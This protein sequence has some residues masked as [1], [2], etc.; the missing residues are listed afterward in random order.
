MRYYFLPEN[1][2]KQNARMILASGICALVV[3]MAFSLFWARFS[4]VALFSDLLGCALLFCGALR[5]EIDRMRVPVFL[6]ALAFCMRIAL[7]IWDPAG[8]FSFLLSLPFSVAVMAGELC[9]LEQLSLFWRA[10]ASEEYSKTLTRAQQALIRSEISFWVLRFI[11]YLS[12]LLVFPALLLFLWTMGIR[13]W[14]S[15]LVF[16]RPESLEGADLLGRKRVRSQ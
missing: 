11:S 16:Q 8:I 1:S 7:V 15:Y 12:D 6:F 14:I 13:L 9:V 5:W 10:R 2:K 3:G 4:L